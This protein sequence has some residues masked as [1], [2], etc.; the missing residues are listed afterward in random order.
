MKAIE[1]CYYVVQ[2]CGT[3]VCE[4]QINVTMH[5]KLSVLTFQV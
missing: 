3:Y 2:V 4:L 1:Q 5:A